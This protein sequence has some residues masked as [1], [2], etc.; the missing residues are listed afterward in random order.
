MTLLEWRLTFNTL[1]RYVAIK[2]EQAHLAKSEL[3]V[4][5]TDFSSLIILSSTQIFHHFLESSEAV[6][7]CKGR[8]LS[9]HAIRA[10]GCG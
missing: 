8:G 10:D 2:E 3:L 1:A 7:C 4:L 5:W 9:R 6:L